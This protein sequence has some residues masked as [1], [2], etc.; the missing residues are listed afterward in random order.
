[1]HE[2][3]GYP[4]LPAHGLIRV[5]LHDEIRC[6]HYSVR[7][8]SI[9]RIGGVLEQARIAGTHSLVWRDVLPEPL[10]FHCRD[11]LACSF[12]SLTGSHICGEES[13]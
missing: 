1:M 4:N 12:K 7:G 13:C 2:R 3:V 5:D 11:C 9:R 10:T 6:S 8:R